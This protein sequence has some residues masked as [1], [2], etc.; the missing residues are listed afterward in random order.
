[1]KTLCKILTVAICSGGMAVA[2]SGVECCQPSSAVCAPA[3]HSCGTRTVRWY[4]AKDGT[5]RE[6]LPYWTALSRA[7]DADDMEIVLR[8]VR[9]ELAE[10]QAAHEAAVADAATQK[11][12]MEAQIAELTKQLEAATQTAAAEKARAD[13]VEAVLADASAKVTTLEGAQ[14]AGEETLAAVRGELT[15]AVQDRDALKAAN[16]DLQK[17]VSELAE[18]RN[19]AEALAKSAQ[20]ELNRLKQDAAPG[21]RP[22]VKEETAEGDGDAEP[23][24]EGTDNP[25]APSSEPS[26]RLTSN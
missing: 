17:Q 12:A 7:E 13:K 22:E 6:Q 26:S 23:K 25:D 16:G 4:K 9:T 10:K 15:A 14:K 18:A 11:A 21:T 2:N 3:G 24:P 8:S 19:A 1:M 20:E 5:Y